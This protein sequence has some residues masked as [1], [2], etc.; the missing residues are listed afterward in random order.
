MRP[1]MSIKANAMRSFSVGVSR[2]GS[3]HAPKVT[4]AGRFAFHAE[5]LRAWVRA[6]S[7]A[8][9]CAV[10]A[11]TRDH[12]KISVVVREHRCRLDPRTSALLGSARVG[13]LPTAMR[14]AD[15]RRPRFV[16]QRQARQHVAHVE[17]LSRLHPEHPACRPREIDV[18]LTLGQTRTGLQGGDAC[19]SLSESSF[20]TAARVTY[21]PPL[22]GSV[23]DSVPS[24]PNV[25]PGGSLAGNDSA[26]VSSTMPSD[27]SCGFLLAMGQG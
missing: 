22:G 14:L 23:A 20:N 16:A 19:E 21:A 17:R 2:G 12:S 13:T 11:A 6:R 7:D 5:D 26:R 9:G 3:A 27:N 15:N 4:T 24:M 25:Q 18:F 8:E 1:A 10:R